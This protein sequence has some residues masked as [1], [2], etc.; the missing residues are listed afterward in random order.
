MQQLLNNLMYTTTHKKGFAIIV[1][2]FES[3]FEHLCPNDAHII[4]S[5]QRRTSG[6]AS[7]LP[8]QTSGSIVF[9]MSMI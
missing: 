7:S 6:C 5:A 1:V 9:W 4:C 8:S 2:D 3:W